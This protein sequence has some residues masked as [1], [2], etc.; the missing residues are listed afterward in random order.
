MR[1]SPSLRA[2][3]QPR[4]PAPVRPRDAEPLDSVSNPFAVIEAPGRPFVFVADG[5]VTPSTRSPA[6]GEITPFFVPPVINTGACEGVPNNDPEHT[7]CDPVPTGLALRVPAT[8]V[9]EHAHERGAGRGPRIRA[10]REHGRGARRH[11]RLQWPDRRRGLA[12]RP[13]YVSE[14]LEG[15][16]EGDGPPPDGFDPST[17][18]RIVARRED[19]TRTYAQVTMPVGL[20]YADGTLYSSAWSVAG[21]SS[22]SRRP[23]RSSPSRRARSR[24][25]A[26]QQRPP[27]PN[28]ARAARAPVLTAPRGRGRPVR[29]SSARRLEGVVAPGAA[30]RG[31]RSQH[32]RLFA[33]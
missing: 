7:G 11:R 14:L 2:R 29:G 18:G 31:S 13:V 23:V 16:P 22:A 28:R 19:G 26:L 8:A 30:I 15:A 9:R 33:L 24:H 21:S 3:Q 4:R 6:T 32:E 12:R 20:D 5:A 25:R 17:I 1:R 10:Q 27:A